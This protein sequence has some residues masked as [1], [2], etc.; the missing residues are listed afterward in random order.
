MNKS[1]IALCVGATFLQLAHAEDSYPNRPIKL[2]VGY[3]PAGGADTVA[4]IVGDALSKELGQPVVIENRP[5]AQSTLASA[6]LASAPADGYTLALGTANIFGVDQH[7]FKAKYKPAD[8]TPVANLTSAP[9][10]L[11]VNQP[12]REKC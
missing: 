7:L 5:G 2:L 4:R 6:L 8:F 12:G 1:F 9:L 3:S 10:L 11:V